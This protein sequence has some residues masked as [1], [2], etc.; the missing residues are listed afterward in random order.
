[1]SESSWATAATIRSLEK[2]WQTA[3][4]NHD[5]NALGRLLADNFSG[6]SA[7]GGEAS[8]ERMLALLRRDQNIYKST[9]VHGM[10]VRNMGAT[11]AVITGTATESGVTAD[12]RKFNVSR[13]FRDTWKQRGGRWE[14]VASRVT[15]A[16]PER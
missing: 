12:G 13:R 4:K 15:T 9:G 16:V 1:L 6:T 2:R 3:V 14:C 8:K 10:S 5:V 7:S 11:A